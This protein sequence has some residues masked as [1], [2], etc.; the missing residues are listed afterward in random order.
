MA[1]GLVT[2]L[3]AGDN[4]NL[5]LVF[6]FFSELVVVLLRAS[7]SDLIFLITNNLSPRRVIPIAIPN[8]S[9]SSW[10]EISATVF[11][12]LN[13]CW[14]K[15]G[16]NSSISFSANHLSKFIFSGSINLHKH[17]QTN[18]H[19]NIHQLEKKCVRSYCARARPDV[20]GRKRG[21]YG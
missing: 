17:C 18:M 7:F 19:V 21:S 11:R 10:L 16:L 5:P 2:Y 1:I 20:F 9:S 13:I 8:C 12:S 3:L 14:T 15:I 4:L 6:H